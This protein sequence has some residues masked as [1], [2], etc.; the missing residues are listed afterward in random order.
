MGGIW[1][2]TQLDPPLPQLSIYIDPNKSEKIPGSAFWTFP[3]EIIG[4]INES[5]PSKP[6]ELPDLTRF[7]SKEQ[8]MLVMLGDLFSDE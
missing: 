8:M 2:A 7:P 4:H 6:M 3:L 1:K 5:I